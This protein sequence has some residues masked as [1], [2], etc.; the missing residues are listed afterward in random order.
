MFYEGKT[1]NRSP[2]CDWLSQGWELSPSLSSRIEG[3]LTP[4]PWPT[5]QGYAVSRIRLRGALSSLLSQAGFNTPVIKW[6]GVERFKRAWQIGG[7]ALWWG[8]GDEIWS[9]KRVRQITY[10]IL[11]GGRERNWL[12]R[13]SVILYNWVTFCL[14]V[15]LWNVAQLQSCEDNFCSNLITFKNFKN[16]FI[17]LIVWEIIIVKL[18]LPGIHVDIFQHTLNLKNRFSRQI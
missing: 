3:Q 7:V 10:M 18:S 1:L 16:A 2:E 11:R 4:A 9:L 15:P 5:N 13:M 8:G 12:N 14:F 17:K 6:N